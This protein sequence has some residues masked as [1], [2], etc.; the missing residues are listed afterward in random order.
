MLPSLSL[1][2]VD[3]DDV[4]IDLDEAASASVTGGAISLDATAGGNKVT[5]IATSGQA[6]FSGPDTQGDVSFVGEEDDARIYA[7]DGANVRMDGSFYQAFL[8]TGAIGTAYGSTILCQASGV[9]LIAHALCE[10][11]ADD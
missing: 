6:S 9:S 8:D 11:Q 2:L 1:S 7:Y 3:A 4:A 5:M 10:Q